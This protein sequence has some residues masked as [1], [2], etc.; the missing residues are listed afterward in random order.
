MNKAE[1]ITKSFS[2][3]VAKYPPGYAYLMMAL[4]YVL[5]PNYEVVIAGRK[6]A[7]DTETMLNALRRPFIP[8]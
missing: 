8:G 4:E 3:S 2:G 1:D 7:S 5:N 6:G